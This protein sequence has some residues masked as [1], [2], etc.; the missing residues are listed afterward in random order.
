MLV[1]TNDVV[2][3]MASNPVMVKEFPFL[4][5]KSLKSSCCS[6]V[7]T[8]FNTPKIRIASMP[9]ARLE[10]FKELMQTDKVKVTYK[11]GGKMNTKE[12]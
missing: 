9:Q 5:L 12:L 10:K 1:V 7:T 3:S 6:K 2:A 8:D 4:K 11:L